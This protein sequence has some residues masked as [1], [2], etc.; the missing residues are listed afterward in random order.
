MKSSILR[1]HSIQEGILFLL[2]GGAL[3][4]HGLDSNSKAFNQDWSQSP[5][6][7]PV[8]VAVLVGA[9]SISLLYQG[10]R[11]GAKACGSQQAAQSAPASAVSTPD[12]AQK[13]QWLPVVIVVGMSL[14]YYLALGMLKIP[15]IT[16]GILSWSLTVSNFEIVTF[17]FLVAMMLYL[18]VR[19]I[20]VLAAVPVCTTLFLSV[21]FRALLHVLL[22]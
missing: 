22:P 21:A 9:L 4:V 18:G 11:A 10:M 16:F 1:N 19:K 14:L 6:L 12:Q 8:L 2:L 17:V 13:G 15:Y 20:L 5:Y 3:L 7:F